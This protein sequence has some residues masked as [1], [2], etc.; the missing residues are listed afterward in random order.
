[1]TDRSPV[2]EWNAAKEFGAP[3]VAPLDVWGRY[4]QALLAAN[5]FVFID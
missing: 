5:E 2:Q 4:A 3:P 1:M